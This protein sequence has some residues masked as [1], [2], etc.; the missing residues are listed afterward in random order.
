MVTVW[1][2]EPDVA[3]TETIEVTGVL[4]EVPFPP[5]PKS[6]PVPIPATIGRSHSRAT[7]LRWKLKSKT[8]KTTPVPGNSER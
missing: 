6:R 4:D 2:S 3:V 7:R 5:Q 1:V 8:A